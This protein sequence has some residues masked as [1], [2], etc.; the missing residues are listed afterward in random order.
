MLSCA[1]HPVGFALVQRAAI[2]ST[3]QA[4]FVG[5]STMNKTGPISSL[6]NG[7]SAVYLILSASIAL[8]LLVGS[9]ASGIEIVGAPGWAWTLWGVSMLSAISIT[10]F[11]GARRHMMPLIVLGCIP[12]LLFF[13]TGA[14]G[15]PVEENSV[16]IVP[17]RELFDL[18]W[19]IALVFAPVFV[20]VVAC[21]G[22][23]SSER[24][25][26]EIR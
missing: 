22:W 10:H 17:M 26:R 11:F 8:G 16:S 25:R 23:Y 7:L 24:E 15:V 18:T 21:A 20:L 4:Q 13:L 2:S 1:A 9:F 19:V 14:L 6:F 5:E 3:I 12:L